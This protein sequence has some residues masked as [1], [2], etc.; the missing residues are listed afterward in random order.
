MDLL[1]EK[2]QF[3]F[4]ALHSYATLS[5]VPIVGEGN[6]GLSLEGT[7]TLFEAEGKHFLVTADHATK[8][9]C[10]GNAG[11]P[12]EPRES[13]LWTPGPGQY[14]CS[15]KF[16]VGVFRIDHAST[17]D[18]LRKAWRF[19][20]LKNVYFG[21]I[22]RDVHFLLYGFPSCL[23]KM[24][25]DTLRTPPASFVTTAYEGEL[26]GFS[27]P[28]DSKVDLMLTH[29]LEGESAKDGSPTSVPDLKGVS[30]CSVWCV[31]P[32]DGAGNDIWSVEKHTKIVA[33]ETSRLRGKWIRCRRWFV[34][35]KIMDDLG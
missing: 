31:P 18:N 7:G 30:G 6:E 32:T 16:D 9:L 8:L 4:E 26:E 24:D 2:E 29:K 14:T 25:K 34:V 33:I 21:D 12:L 5:T 3:A 1:P 10:E 20:S 13:E 19:L 11:I 28:Y 35:K 15:K 17:V 23:A 27:D 22:P